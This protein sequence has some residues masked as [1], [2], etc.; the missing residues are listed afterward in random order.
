MPDD[1]VEAPADGRVVVEQRG[2]RARH[3]ED[4]DE[5]AL[6]ALAPLSRS[7][8]RGP[9]AGEQPAVRRPRRRA[10]HTLADRSHVDLFAASRPCQI[11]VLDFR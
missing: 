2:V 8:V 5:V 6:H 4:V 9:H 3:V 10:A 11:L 7:S 1:R